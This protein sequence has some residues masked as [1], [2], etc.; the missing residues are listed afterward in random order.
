MLMC[1]L[2]Q[3]I[4]ATVGSFFLLA[5]SNLGGPL[6]AEPV[7]VTQQGA[8]LVVGQ[9]SFTR[10]A[11]ISSRETIG[12]VAGVAYGGDILVIADGN[13]VG[14]QPLNNRVLIYRNVSSF[15][16][17]PD[18]ELDQTSLCPA[19]VGVADVVLGQ[20]DFDTFAPGIMTGLQNPTGVATDGVRIAVAD[21]NNNR[22]LL[23]NSIPTQNGALPD[24]VLGQDG[25]D[26]NMAGTSNNTMR[27]PQGVWFDG[28]RV[29]S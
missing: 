7:W 27:G 22:V 8:R 10:Q 4:A 17:S 6:R 26:S 5:L 1:R 21:T 25:L 12:G 29:G 15:V 16:P 3:S 13:R 28:G 14:S 24:V 11:P 2:H 20:P 19:C 18:L 23:W 9:P